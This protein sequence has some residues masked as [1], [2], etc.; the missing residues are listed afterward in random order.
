MK[1]D[2]KIEEK[3]IILENKSKNTNNT[4]YKYDITKDNSSAKNDY[5][6][7]DVIYKFKAYGTDMLLAYIGQ[8]TENNTF[9]SASEKDSNNLRFWT[10]YNF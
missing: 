5:Q 3:I 8:K 2:K 6:E 7:L 4:L 1:I 10:K 9:A